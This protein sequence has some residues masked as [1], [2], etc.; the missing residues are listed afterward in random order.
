MDISDIVKKVQV[1]VPYPLLQERIEKVRAYGLN[2][3]IFFDAPALDSAKEADLIAYGE[4]FKESEKRV[5]V[6]GPFMDLFP[7]AVDEEVRL[8]T[9]KRYKQA[10]EVARHLGAV[11]LVLHAE[12]DARRYD[13]DEDLWLTQSMKTWPELVKI[14]ESQGTVIVVENIFEERPR[15]LKRIIEAVDS[16][17]FKICLDIGHMNIFSKVEM[18]EWFSELGEHL[19]EVHVHDN[20]GKFDEHLPVGEGRIDFA[21]FFK[22]LNNCSGD[23]VLTLEPHGEEALEPALMG[24]G[25]WL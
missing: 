7:G 16:K 25:E 17:N 8:V 1:H 18:E 11:R 19:G 20:N 14:A 5:T 6:H 13:E 15:S 21:R 2:P 4:A 22:L 3:E 12:Y 10:L 9:V 23:V 24:V